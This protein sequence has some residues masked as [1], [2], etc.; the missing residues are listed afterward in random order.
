[1]LVAR[2]WRLSLPNG[3]RAAAMMRCM[4]R[5]VLVVD[6]DPGFRG[7]AARLLAAS[8]LTVIGE[9]DSV[10]AAL[11]AAGRLEPS[12]VLVDAELP[13]GDGI[14]LARELAAL[15]WRPRIV[16]TSVDRDVTA[17]NAR[18]AGATEFVNKV[19]LASAPLAEL[20]GGE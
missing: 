1:M 13:D 11:S 8:G 14:T 16:L 12:G 5:S 15:P 18:R 19:D 2:Q 20:L 9:A 3:T 10:S 6:N 17:D 7:L 4:T